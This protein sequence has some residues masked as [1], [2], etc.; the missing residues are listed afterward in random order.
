M[1]VDSYRY[2]PRSFREGYEALPLQAETPV[3]APL[4]VPVEQASIALM[5]SAGLFLKDE[6]PPFDTEREIANP[7]WGDP[8]YRVIPGDVRQ[9]QIGAAHLHLNTRDFFEDFNVALAL[10]AFGELQTKGRIGQLAD[11]HYS[12]MGYQER[13]V[14]EW[15]EH[16]GPEV[17]RRLKD[18]G[19]HALV[20]APA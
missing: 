8:T 4:G 12:F 2:L 7:L 17:A 11:E 5:T 3:W 1:A 14:A 16:Y 20:L 19:V 18:A 10:R 6:Q 15:R 13:T 9:E